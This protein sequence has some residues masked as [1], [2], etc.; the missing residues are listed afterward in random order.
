EVIPYGLDLTAFR[1]DPDARE[2]HRARMGTP[3]DRLVVLFVGDDFERKGLDQAIC[4]LGRTSQDSELWIAGRGAQDRYRELAGSLGLT[5][6][7]H[8]LGRVPNDQLAKVYSAADVFVLPS[9]QDAW[10]HTVIE[11]MAANRPVIVSPFA[12]SEEV[13]ESG[14]SGFVLEP[15]D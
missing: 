12:G 8:F 9:R 15:G 4:A 5:E 14:V 6:R 13:V 3:A 7:T 2:E 11:A 1:F 10:G